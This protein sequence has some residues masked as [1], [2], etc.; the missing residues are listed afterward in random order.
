MSVDDAAFQAAVDALIAR[1]HAAG[2]VAVKKATLAI[3]AAGMANTKVVSGSNRRSW[4]M[5]E[6]GPFAAFTGPTMVYSR[7]LELGFKGPDSLGRVYNQAPNPYV[8][9]A[10]DSMLPQVRPF[11]IAAISGALRG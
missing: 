7:R 9:P 11:F 8:R 1:V 4:R 2:A 6:A 5:E 10:Y 3:Q